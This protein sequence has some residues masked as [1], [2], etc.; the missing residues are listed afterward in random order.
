LA[1][2]AVHE[3]VTWRSLAVA[4][5]AAAAAGAVASVVAADDVATA[6]PSPSELRAA[7]LKK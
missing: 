3:S 2:G 4:V 7:T 5:G 1:A 6:A